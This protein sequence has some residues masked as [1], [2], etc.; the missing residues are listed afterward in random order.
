MVRQVSVRHALEIVVVG[1]LCHTSVDKRPG[2]IVDGILFVFY[3]LGDNLRAEV[4]VE[5]VVEMTL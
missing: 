3:R 5:T 1:V 4:V 2:E